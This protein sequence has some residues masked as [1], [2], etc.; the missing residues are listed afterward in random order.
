M[1]N[2]VKQLETKCV[3]CK[4]KA[5]MGV[6]MNDYEIPYCLFHFFEYKRRERKER[7]RA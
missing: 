5:E 4:N 7:T 6:R 3:H 2:R 1:K